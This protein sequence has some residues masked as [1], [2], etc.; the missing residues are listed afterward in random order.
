MTKFSYMKVDMWLADKTKL[1][2]CLDPYYDLTC[3]MALPNASVS[4][5]P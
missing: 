5:G 4:T 1:I 2:L 3:N